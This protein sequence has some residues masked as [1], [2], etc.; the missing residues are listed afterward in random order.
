VLTIGDDTLRFT[1]RRFDAA[2]SPAG[3]S[4][5]ALNGAGA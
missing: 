4:E 2:G 1:E 5:Y 3:E